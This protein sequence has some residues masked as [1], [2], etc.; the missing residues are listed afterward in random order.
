MPYRLRNGAYIIKCCYPGC[1]FDT[2]FEI[3]QNISGI[4]EQDVNDEAKKL[5]IGMAQIKHDAVYGTK[6]PLTDPRIRQVRGSFESIG[7]TKDKPGSGKGPVSYRLFQKGEIIIKK[8]EDAT[9]VCEVKHGFAYPVHN[10]N[11]KYSIGEC[12]GAAALMSHHD[13]TTDILSG[14]NGT[15]IAFYNVIELSKTDA[16]KAGQLYNRTMEDIFKVI[17]E[18][19]QKNKKLEKKLKEKK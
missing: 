10:R 9:T 17:G 5:A 15:K 16:K 8:G 12:F 6:H 7:A 3:N 1:S 19:E 18:L 13:R 2:K 4:T 11:H 14:E